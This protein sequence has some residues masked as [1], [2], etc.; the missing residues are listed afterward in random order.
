MNL[1]PGEEAV[2]V[3]AEDQETEALR[4]M[5]RCQKCNTAMDSYLN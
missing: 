2:S 1:T 4:A 3:L 5:H